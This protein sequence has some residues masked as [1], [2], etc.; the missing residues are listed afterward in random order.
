MVSI[1]ISTKEENEA[2]MHAIWLVGFDVLVRCWVG[3]TTS[4]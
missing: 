3:S 2:I 1:P 4:I